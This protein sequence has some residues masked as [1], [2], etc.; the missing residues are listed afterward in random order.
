MTLQSDTKF[1]G[2]LTCGLENEMR[3]LA[4]FHQSTR[5]SQNSDFDGI[6]FIQSKKYI[7]LKFTG[8]MTMSND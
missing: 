7:S 6:L 4:N 2:K 3:S 8:A 5:K 1:E